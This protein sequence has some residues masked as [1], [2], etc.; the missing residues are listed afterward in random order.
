MATRKPGTR[1]GIGDFL[2]DTQARSMERFGSSSSMVRWMVGV[3][4]SA[5]IGG[6]GFP[7]DEAALLRVV[8]SF[9]I[10]IICLCWLVSLVS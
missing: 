3:M 8:V 10:L 6:Y 9:G 7:G 2:S 1:I 4:F 5:V